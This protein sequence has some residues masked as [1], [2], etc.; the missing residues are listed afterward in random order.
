MKP[1]I[2]VL[3]ILTGCTTKPLADPAPQYFEADPAT[4]ATVTGKVSFRGKPP[5]M[6]PLRIDEDP[7]CSNLNPKGLLDESVVVSRKGELANVFVY[8]KTGLEGKRFAPPAGPATIDQRNCRFAPRVLGV[9]VGQT[10]RVLNSDPLTHNIHPQPKESRE[11]NQ[12]QP[13]GAP[14]LER[15]FVRPEIMLRVK[16]N[17]HSW[18]RGYWSV[19]EHPYF[20]VTGPNGEFRITG[21]PPGKYILEAG[22][23]S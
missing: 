3:L 23:R 15:K 7:V 13:E 2:A 9:R 20:A 4:A 21:L 1:A 16:C 11:W 5:K 18:M 12:S 6:A 22:M 19:L 8:V 10:I 14:A 17:V